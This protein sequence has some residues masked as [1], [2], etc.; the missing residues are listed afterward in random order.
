MNALN[1][2]TRFVIAGVTENYKQPLAGAPFEER[3]CINSN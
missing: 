3:G 2:S 1:C